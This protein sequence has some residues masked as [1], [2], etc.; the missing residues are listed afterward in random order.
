MLSTVF[1]SAAT[2]RD[3]SGAETAIGLTI[4]VG[5]V[6]TLWL[7]PTIIACRRRVLNVGSI[8]VLNVLIGWMPFGWIIV[9]AMACQTSPHP[10]RRRERH[11]CRLAGDD[12]R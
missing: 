10:S 3:H 12:V 11:E 8:A 6:V 1:I 2:A 7:L 5:I 4:F 9:L